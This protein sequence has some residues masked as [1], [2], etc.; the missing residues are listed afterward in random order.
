MFSVVL[1]SPFNNFC[2][3]LLYL[4]CFLHIPYC[5]FIS[6]FHK[7]CFQYGLH[8]C[9]GF[10][11]SFNFFFE[12]C[13]LLFH[14]LLAAPL[15][16]FLLLYLFFELLCC[17]S[18]SL[19]DF[20]DVMS[21]YLIMDFSCFVSVSFWSLVVFCCLFFCPLPPFFHSCKSGANKF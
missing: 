13:K 18:I 19:L 14:L 8:F 16:F 9:N 12:L 21:T 6:G 10:V 11:F 7:W 2:S 20:F 5:I 3:F 1:S 17:R 15:I 4:L